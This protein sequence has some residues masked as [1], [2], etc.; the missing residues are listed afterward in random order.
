MAE[1]LSANINTRGLYGGEY[2]SHKLSHGTRANLY[3]LP[4]I[5]AMA[6]NLVAGGLLTSMLGHPMTQ[7]LTKNNYT[8]WKL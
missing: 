5:I 1:A 7:K 4:R 2:P 3:P 8:L 6:T